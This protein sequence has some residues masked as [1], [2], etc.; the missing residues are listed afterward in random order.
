MSPYHPI[1]GFALVTL[2]AGC[3][4]TDPRDDITTA[5]LHVTERSGL[6]PDW[7]SPPPTAAL[8]DPLDVE[9]ATRLALERHPTLRAAVAAVAAA[10]ADLVQAG[11]LANPT[12]RV[13]LGFPLD[14]GA[15][16]PG[17]IGVMAPLA[18]LWTRPARLAAADAELRSAVLELSDRALRTVEAVGVACATVHHTRARS[19]LDARSVAVLTERLSL[20]T[21]LSDAGESDRL[22]V[23]AARIELARARDREIRSREAVAAAERILLERLGA[24]TE[25]TSCPVLDPASLPLAGAKHLSEEELIER[26]AVRRLDVAAALAR[27][28]AAGARLDLAGRER[29]GTVAATVG[30]EQN[31]DERDGVFPGIEFAP[32]IFDPGHAAVARRNAEAEQR[33]REAESTLWSALLETRLA[34]TALASA[35]ER[36]AQID[37]EWLPAALERATL[38]EAWHSVGEGTRTE[39][40]LGENAALA[41]RRERNEAELDARIA[42]C[43]LIRAVGGSLAPLTDEEKARV[44]ATPRVAD[45]ILSA[46]RKVGR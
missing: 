16:S 41:A 32:P 27:A 6:A 5:S 2:L 30:Y 31:F 38:F 24:V 7:L 37:A 25:T 43:A 45:S 3:G 19:G 36:L 1:Y 22:A 17:M 35:Q 11:L 46:A 18:A 23:D 28:E 20:V 10:R 14:G 15:G 9:T 44:A 12:F 29:F 33:A 26:V 42:L 40:L 21:A 8:P 4:S 13:A 34:H 39:A